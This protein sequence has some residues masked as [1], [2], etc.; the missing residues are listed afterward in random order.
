MDS[1]LPEL[2]VDERTILSAVIERK[3]ALRRPDSLWREWQRKNNWR[4]AGLLKYIGLALPFEITRPK[5]PVPEYAILFDLPSYCF[6]MYT[7]VG[8]AMLKRIVQGVDGA[9]AIKE[10]FQQNRVKIPHK[11]LGEALFS[12]EGGRIREELIYEPL[13]CLEERLFAHRF[14]L[15]P[16]AWLHLR[17]LVAEVLEVGVVDRV[18]REVLRQF[19]A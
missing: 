2:L 14:G 10:L 17:A 9:E 5:T 6:D 18:R 7:R 12:V 4:A 16:N 1:E 13:C 8:L 3:A 19:Y 11:V 15:T